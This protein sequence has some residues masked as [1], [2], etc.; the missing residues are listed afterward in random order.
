ML[1]KKRWYVFLTQP[2]IRYWKVWLT[3]T[4]LEGSDKGT[5]V[6]AMEA[7]YVAM[8][9]ERVRKEIAA[10]NDRRIQ[11]YAT[12]PDLANSLNPSDEPFPPEASARG[13]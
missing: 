4:F 9:N 12:L 6:P 1:K 3:Q 13:E 10:L 5:I 11:M 2:L 8:G 7:V